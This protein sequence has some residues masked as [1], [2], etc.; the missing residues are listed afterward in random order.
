MA[1]YILGTKE[2]TV[3][4][5]SDDCL[6]RFIAD[7]AC[8][9]CEVHQRYLQDSYF[10]DD[11]KFEK[12]DMLEYINRVEKIPIRNTGLKDSPWTRWAYGR[13]VNYLFLKNLGL[14]AVKEWDYRFSL[15][16]WHNGKK[17]IQWADK[18][19]PDF[20]NLNN[21]GPYSFP[22]DFPNKYM[23]KNKYPLSLDSHEFLI[24][25]YRNYYD[26]VISRNAE[27]FTWT[28][29]EGAKSAYRYRLK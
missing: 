22:M 27:K 11:D 15:L 13:L 14:E 9:L 20:F 3:E 8:V 12:K 25:S 21:D 19:L 6:G 7:I 10:L 18:N 24:K 26:S 1:I 28:K 17:I 29:R 23:H 5:L 2:Q 4:A 16:K